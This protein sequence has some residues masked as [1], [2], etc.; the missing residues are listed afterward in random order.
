MLNIL[1]KIES[2]DVTVRELASQAL[3]LVSDRARPPWCMRVFHHLCYLIEGCIVTAPLLEQKHVCALGD[4]LYTQ[5]LIDDLGAHTA[6][7]NF[8]LA[9]FGM[10]TR[11]SDIQKKDQKFVQTLGNLLAHRRGRRGRNRRLQTAADT[12]LTRSAPHCAQGAWNTQIGQRR[13]P[14]HFAGNQH[15]M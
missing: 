14:P 7:S 10:Y 3:L 8:L 4:P 11:A 2:R 5:I 12:P 6:P 15:V 13:Q 1:S 9:C